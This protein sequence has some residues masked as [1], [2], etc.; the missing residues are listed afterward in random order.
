MKGNKVR[1]AIIGVGN[2]ASSLVQGVHYYRDADESKFVPGL[3][4]V[5]LGGYHV[6]DIEFSAA[7][8]VDANKVDKDLSEA[9]FAPPNNTCRFADVPQ[10]NVRVRRGMTHD[11]L[12]RYLSGKI[13]KAP[14]ATDDI[15]A[16]LRASRTD[17]VV[18]Y[19]P[20]GSEM[21]TK[22]YVEQVLAAGC[23]FVNCIPVFIAS[24]SYWR[25]RFKQRGLPLIGDDIKSQLGATITHRA[26]AHLFRDR[27]VRLDRTYQ[28]NFG[29]NTDFL[30]MLERERLE[31][32]KISKTRAVTSQLDYPLSDDDAHVGP[33]DYVPWLKDRKWCYIRLEGTTFGDVPLNCE[34]KLEVWDSPNSAGVVIDA[35]RCARLAL[36]RGIGGALIGPASYFMKSPPRQ[37]TDHEARER[38]EEFIRND[39]ASSAATTI[40]K[41]HAAR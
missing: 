10:A 19:L 37:F 11:G 21:A 9:I 3:M 23:A 28:L 8:D 36:D 1:V 31:S 40:S 12:G 29:G 22:W 17:V 4:H 41:A 33:S 15:V 14:G 30:N 13:Q 32:K 25:R 27:G 5:N 2:C 35:V 38:T 20:V 6:R 16:T 39:S 34:V 24:Q 7:F 26:L 18:S